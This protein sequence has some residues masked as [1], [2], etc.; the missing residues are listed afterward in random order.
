MINPEDS[1]HYLPKTGPVIFSQP[2]H[3]QDQ[4][5]TEISDDS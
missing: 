4:V 3:R 2:S 1:I 5:S